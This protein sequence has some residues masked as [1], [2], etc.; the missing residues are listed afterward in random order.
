MLNQ[1]KSKM[2]KILI[3]LTSRFFVILIMTIFAAKYL[4]MARLGVEPKT[5]GEIM[6]SD[7]YYMCF[8][9]IVISI[10]SV[11]VEAKEKDE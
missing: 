4:G 10:L 8:L 6:G 5:W 9:S 7:I 2:R 11:Y 3:K 1:T